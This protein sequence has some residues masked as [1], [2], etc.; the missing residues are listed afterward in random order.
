M[1]RFDLSLYRELLGPALIERMLA[2]RQG[3]IVSTDD[4]I[5]LPNEHA[6]G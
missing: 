1:S 3:L 4:V 5:F 6:N 2:A